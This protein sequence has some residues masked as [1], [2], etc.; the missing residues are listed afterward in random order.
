M[1]ITY[2]WGVKTLYVLQTPKE[3][4]VSKIS[5]QCV[6]VDS[7][8]YSSKTSDLISDLKQGESFI[9][10]ADLKDQEVTYIGKRYKVEDAD[11]F[12][13]KL[14]ALDNPA[15]KIKVNLNQFNEKGF[16]H[17]MVESIRLGYNIDESKLCKRGRD[18]IAARK[19]AGEKSSAYLS[20]R[21]VKVC[22][23]QIKGACGKRKKSYKSK[24]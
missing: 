5:W 18:Y 17:E 9:A 10:F 1:A 21:A 2:T 22:K 6:G 7:D 3:N 16:I 23:G 15:N 4:F 14:Q 13:L 8:N 11:G 24:K 12:V 20:V 19:R